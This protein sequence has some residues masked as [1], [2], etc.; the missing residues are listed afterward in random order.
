MGAEGAKR[1]NRRTIMPVIVVAS[2]VGAARAQDLHR[3]YRIAAGGVINVTNISGDIRVSGAAGDSIT[4]SALRE[5]RDRDLVQIE[6]NSGAD[7]V[8]LRVRYPENCNCNVNVRF[9][10]QV[11]RGVSYTFDSISSVSGDV[12]ISD[13]TGSLRAKTVSGNVRIKDVAAVVSASTV[14]GN[15]DVDISRLV[16]NGDMKFSSVSG[17]VSVRVPGTLDAEVEMSSVSGSLRTDF[18]IQVEE[19]RYGPGRKAR[20]RVG[21]GSRA[22]RLSTVS[23]RVSLSRM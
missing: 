22:L 18:P 19:A 5:G 4:V 3:T 14:S 7:R 21:S 2:L 17:S 8:S 1:M 9:D 6:D 12:D 15:V 11:P 16:G 20:G 23:G 10:I 13:V